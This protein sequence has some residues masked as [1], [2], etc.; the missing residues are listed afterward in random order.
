MQGYGGSVRVLKYN[1]ANLKI[2]KNASLFHQQ[3]SLISGMESRMI[4]LIYIALG[5]QCA[6]PLYVLSF[7]LPTKQV[8]H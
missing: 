6:K 7:C 5:L 3:S 8:W 1:V 2:E 4:D